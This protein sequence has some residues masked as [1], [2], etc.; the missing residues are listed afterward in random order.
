MEITELFFNFLLQ[1][2]IIQQLTQNYPVQ[3]DAIFPQHSGKLDVVMCLLEELKCT[4]EKVVLV[5][6]FTQVG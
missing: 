6:Y 1:E 5:S 4:K 3:N 2:D